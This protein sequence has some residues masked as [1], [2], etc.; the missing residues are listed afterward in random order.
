MKDREIAIGAAMSLLV[1]SPDLCK[2]RKGKVTGNLIASQI[3]ANK[4]QW[5]GEEEL[6]LSE[7]AISDLIEQYL[8]LARPVL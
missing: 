4:K 2:N 7:S 6:V 1:N 8:R 3:M 5:F